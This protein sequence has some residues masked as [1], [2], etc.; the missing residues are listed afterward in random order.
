MQLVLMLKSKLLLSEVTQ[1]YKEF[2]DNLKGLMKDKQKIMLSLS[3]PHGRLLASIRSGQT[4]VQHMPSTCV[5]ASTIAVSILNV[6]SSVLNPKYKY[7]AIGAWDELYR[8]NTLKVIKETVSSA[9]ISLVLCLIA[10]SCR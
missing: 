3:G 8:V 7:K 9:P 1:V 10:V 5:S 6:L 4:N 2:I